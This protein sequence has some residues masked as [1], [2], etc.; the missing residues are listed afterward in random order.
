MPMST[1]PEERKAKNFSQK[2]INYICILY[3]TMRAAM[4]LMS[5]AIT[6]FLQENAMNIKISCAGS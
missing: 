6:L 2:V 4:A 5:W 3:N 1:Y